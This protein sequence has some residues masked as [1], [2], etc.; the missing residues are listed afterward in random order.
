MLKILKDKTLSFRTFVAEELNEAYEEG[1]RFAC[2]GNYETYGNDPW[3]GM[4]NVSSDVFLFTDYAEAK[5]FAVTQVWPFNKNLTSKV[6]E[7]PAHTKTWKEMM[8]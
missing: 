5:Q 2:E 8:E 6:V 3:S 7:I 1:Y 4:P